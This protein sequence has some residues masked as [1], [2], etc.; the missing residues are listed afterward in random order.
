[1]A[2]ASRRVLILGAGG[3]LGRRVGEV[4]GAKQWHTIGAD[5]YAK[6]SARHVLNIDPKATPEAQCREAVAQLR[7]ALAEDGGRLDAIVNVAGGFA[8]GSAD[9]EAMVENTRAMIESSVYSSVLAAHCASRFLKPHGLLVLP[10][11]AAAYSPTAWSLP[12]GVCKVAVHHIVRSL[13]EPTAAG[14]ADGVKTIGLAP[15]T[16]DTPQNRQAMPDADFSTWAS[17]DEVAGQLESW[18]ADP[19]KVESGLVYVIEKA[20]GAPAQF[21]PRAPL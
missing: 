12:Y 11:A 6:A 21:S 7:G 10:G 16:L 15:V 13:A 5:A 2:A 17:L 9:D 18:S 3:Q 8:M 14:L 19:S 1:M 20:S 4:F